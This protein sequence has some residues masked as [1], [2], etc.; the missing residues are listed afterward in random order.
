MTRTR[1]I[2]NL[3]EVVFDRKRLNVNLKPLNDYKIIT[4]KKVGIHV[5]YSLN[6]TKFA[7]EAIEL[8]MDVYQGSYSIDETKWLI[9]RYDETIRN[10]QKL[11]TKNID[12]TFKE[13]T[14]NLTNLALFCMAD[15]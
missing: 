3:N 9:G 6:K 14:L 15:G 2:L 7:K 12:E 8:I 10:I 1:E 4:K 5:F 11:R 13:F